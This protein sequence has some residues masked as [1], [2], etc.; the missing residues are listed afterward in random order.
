MSWWVSPP[1]PPLPPPPLSPPTLPPLLPPPPPS[2]PPLDEVV[3]HSAFFAI[4]LLVCI[5]NTLFTAIILYY[6]VRSLCHRRVRRPVP[7]RVYPPVSVL[8]PCYLP[9]EQVRAPPSAPTLLW[10]T[11]VPPHLLSQGII[12]GTIAHVLRRLDYPA[13]LKLFIVYNTPHNLPEIEADLAALEPIEF[14]DDRRVCVLRASD[15]RSKA[16]NLNLVLGMVTDDYVAIYDADHHA[17]PDSLAHMMDMLQAQGCD[18]VQGSTYIRNVASTAGGE[19]LCRRI[20]H[21]LLA[22]FISAEFF[23]QHFVYF[24]VMEA[25]S[26]SG[27]F[28]GSNALW[29]TDVLRGFQ[30]RKAMQTEDIDVSARAILNN[31]NIA[32]CPEARSGELSPNDFASLYRQRLRWALG[33][34]QVTLS[35]IKVMWRSRISWQ[36][37]C[38]VFFMFPVRWVLLVLSL[39]IGVVSPILSVFIALSEWGAG[40]SIGLGYA[41]G[42]YWLIAISALFRAVQYEHPRQ[43]LWVLFFYCAAPLYVSLNFM[44]VVI[45]TIKICSGNVGAWHVTR[46]SS[47]AAGRASE[48]GADDRATP[49]LRKVPTWL[50]FNRFATGRFNQPE[51][52]LKDEDVP[53][54]SVAQILSEEVVEFGWSQ[55]GSPRGSPRGSMRD[56]REGSPREGWSPRDDARS[57]VRVTGQLL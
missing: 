30:F 49:R 29:R 55:P 5:V 15:S 47:A 51:E 21:L 20:R 37:K 56:S 28:G 46:R 42:T 54:E 41:L 40:I 18:A 1:P 25:L 31:H 39:F 26:A 17:D 33:W 53:H 50:A 43:W 13:P 12:M 52:D 44:L 10:P 48:P 35:C 36:R 19:G 9:N 34:D 32:F 23:V 14:E 6:T 2:A 8:I 3:V 45:S 27:F 24:P 57:P 7:G 4:L 16:E 11:P 22:R 38:G